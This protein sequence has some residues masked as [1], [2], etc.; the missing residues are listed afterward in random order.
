M[1]KSL[2]ALPALS[3]QLLQERNASI[4]DVMVKA[5]ADIVDE[6]QGAPVMLPIFQAGTNRV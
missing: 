5:I 6:L 3:E 4:K 2:K 1:L